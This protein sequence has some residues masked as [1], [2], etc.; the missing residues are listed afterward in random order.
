MRK[1]AAE[2]KKLSQHC[3][4]PQEWLPDA[5]ITQFIVGIRNEDL[6]LKLIQEQFSEFPKTVEFAVT[7]E[8]SKQLRRIR[9]QMLVLLLALKM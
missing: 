7:F 1:F 9:F 8:L 3:Q 4:F 6:S 5:L 2:L